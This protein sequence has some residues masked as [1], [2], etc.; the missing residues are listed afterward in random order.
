MGFRHEC[1]CGGGLPSLRRTSKRLA[2]SS[3]RLKEVDAHVLWKERN[4]LQSRGCRTCSAEV[5]STA[6]QAKGSV[7]EN[8]PAELLSSTAHDG[9]GDRASDG[10]ARLRLL[11]WT[12]LVVVAV[13]EAG[14]KTA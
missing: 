8:K 10:V 9:G 1:I 2:A 4:N 6:W 3:S 7:S 14:D 13:D 12:K 5:E 11:P